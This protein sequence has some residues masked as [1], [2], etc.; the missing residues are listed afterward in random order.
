MA[1]S[2]V[3]AIPWWNFCLSSLRVQW[4]EQLKIIFIILSF[5]VFWANSWN[6]DR[7]DSL[8]W[9]KH[10]SVWQCAHPDAQ[11]PLQEGSTKREK[12]RHAEPA[13]ATI[14]KPNWAIRAN[15]NGYQITVY[16]C[17]LCTHIVSI[18]HVL[19]YY[20]YILISYYTIILHTSYFQCSFRNHLCCSWGRVDGKK[21]VV[22]WGWLKLTQLNY[23]VYTKCILSVYFC[24]ARSS[25]TYSN[26]PKQSRRCVS[27]AF[28]G[29]AKRLHVWKIWLRWDCCEV[30]Q[31]WKP[32]YSPKPPYSPSLYPSKHGLIKTLEE[33]KKDYNT[34]ET[35]RKK[36]ILI[37]HRSEEPSFRTEHQI[38][39]A[40]GSRSH[41]APKARDNLARSPARPPK[42]CSWKDHGIMVSKP[43]IE[44]LS[45]IVGCSLDLQHE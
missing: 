13:I 11:R 45:L 8:D 35:Y 29:S 19:L 17:I 42:C 21:W 4:Q 39:A 24:V 2:F 3:L 43:W 1:L 41:Q 31:V 12:Q 37:G 5:L 40:N 14:P 22:R 9:C 7:L 20:I 15:V 26:M 32:T 27:I 30:T 18:W 10:R 23:T 28:L 33:R 44:R 16:I 25:L 6:L 34:I 36:T 38:S